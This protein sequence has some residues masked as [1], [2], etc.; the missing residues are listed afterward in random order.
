MIR[1]SK[2][3]EFIVICLVILLFC[4]CS[5]KEDQQSQ[6][7]NQP[8]VDSATSTKNQ[9]DTPPAVNPPDMSTQMA[10]AEAKNRQALL[11]MNQGK[12]VEPV[13]TGTLKEMLP[14][15]LP[16]MTRSNA[17]VERNQMM[18]IDIA[19]A[20]ADYRATGNGESS[21]HIMIMD[22][23]N[24]SGPMKM[25]MASW[26]MTQYSRET[27]NGYEKTTT[28]NGNKAVEEY[29]HVNHQGKL[30]VFVAGRFIVEVTGSQASMETIMRTTD[31]IDIK[32]LAALASD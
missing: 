24:M 8:P 9:T 18:G 1:I 16:G 29:D 2:K 11:A 31:K 32:K 21:V 22:M 5:K 7:T 30:R 20:Q 6:S 19:Q 23:G 27:D 13:D 26:A 12:A 28:Y 15:E 17:S 10:D 3:Y 4:G 14:A 25:G